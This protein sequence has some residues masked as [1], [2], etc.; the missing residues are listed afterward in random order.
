MPF[1]RKL[2]IDENREDPL[3]N[4]HGVKNHKVTESDHNKIELF[5]NIEAPVIQP[6]RE[7]IFTFK[8][9]QGQYLFHDITNSSSK[10]RNSFK[11]RNSFIDQASLF[12][13]TLQGVFHQ[14]F[15]KIRGTKRK[16]RLTE[17]D[18]LFCERKKIKLN[19]K[20]NTS[21]NINSLANI[22]DKIAQIISRKNRVKIMNTLQDLANTDS[23]CNTL[24]MWSQVRK[25]F[26]KVLASAPSG[27]RDHNG[28]I[29]T[30]VSTVK[31]IIIR[32]YQQKLRKRPANPLI[33]DLMKI[34]EQNA[35]R[36]I[37]LARNTKTANWTKKD[38]LVVLAKLKN[39]KSRDPGGLINEL[40][41]ES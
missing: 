33:K 5:L 11:S 31:Q 15:K 36:I 38:L 35:L 18:L 17:I 6:K 28:K 27:L 9:V 25:I 14:S 4:Y 3:T 29:R 40:N 7:E 24:G 32:K 41:L 34:K 26:P 10:L 1:V 16:A 12:Q 39:G 21:K 13:K 30:K 20:N 8:E 22:E 19:L 37:E 23:S 2:F